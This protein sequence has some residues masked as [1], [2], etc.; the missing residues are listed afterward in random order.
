MD[1]NTVSGTPAPT[2]PTPV[3]STPEPAPKKEGWRSIAST[4]AVIVLAPLVAIFMIAFV[5][6]S[7][8]V[9]GPSMQTTLN[10]DD[11]L[12]V[13]KLSR[14]W[15]RLTGHPYTPNRGDV[16]VFNQKGLPDGDKQLIKRAVGLPGDR[17]VVQ[18]GIVTVYNKEH[19]DGYQP[20]K[21]LPYG[22]VI[23]DTEPEIAQQEWTVG[24]D[25]FFALGDNRNDSL[26]SRTFGPVSSDQIVGKL[27]LRVAP[28]SQMKRF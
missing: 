3:V 7:Y 11:R 20:D 24:K 15:S 22:K 13:W 25:E 6:Q 2:T 12:I 14:S 17:I 19:P 8:Q 4:V 18:N 26:D 16:I 23:G 28:F 5:F 10:N 21:T 27:V 9:S 1:N